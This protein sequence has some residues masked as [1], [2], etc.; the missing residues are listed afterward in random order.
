MALLARFVHVV[1][2]GNQQV[3]F[4]LALLMESHMAMDYRASASAAS[5]FDS[6]LGGRM[7]MNKYLH[8]SVS[9]ARP[10]VR[11]FVRMIENTT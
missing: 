4:H 11:S 9:G 3:N 10:T 7:I 1:R 6:G 5:T 2:L 8:T